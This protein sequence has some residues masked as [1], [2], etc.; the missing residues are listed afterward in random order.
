MFRIL[1]K[2]FRKRIKFWNFIISGLGLCIG[3]TL[4]LFSTRIYFGLVKPAQ[5]EIKRSD[6]VIISKGVSIGNTLLNSKAKFSGQELSQLKEQKF[7][8]D[9]AMFTPNQFTVKAYAGGGI[10][11]MTDLF[12][13]SVPN[14]FIDNCPYTFDWEEGDDF[15]PIIV[16]EDFINLYNY[17]FA[18]INGLPQVSPSSVTAVP[19]KIVMQGPNGQYTMSGRI[20]GYSERIASVLVPDRFLRWANKEIGG[21]SKDPDV[22]RLMIKVNKEYAASMQEYMTKEG[23]QVNSERLGQNKTSAIANILTDVLVVLGALFILFSFVIVLQNFSLILSDARQDMVLLMQ[24]GYKIGVITRFL[25]FVLA[26]YLALVAIFSG[27]LYAVGYSQLT[28]YLQNRSLESGNAINFEVT[29]LL[30]F[31]LVLLMLTGLV[32]IRYKVQKYQK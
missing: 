21:V 15:L 11:F 8:S 9:V 30:L 19:L 18:V 31:V 20:V 14:S 2:I 3:L 13:E 12:F 10:P 5:D 1:S 28:H 25:F 16:S 29:A 4:V 7:T 22:A 6:Y 27:I 23:Y 24:L 32:S 17:S 26:G